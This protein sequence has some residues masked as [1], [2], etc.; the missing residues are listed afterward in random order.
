MVEARANSDISLVAE[1]SSKLAQADPSD[2]L[3]Q[4]VASNSYLALNNLELAIAFAEKACLAETDHFGHQ[5]HCGGLKNRVG[6]FSGALVIFLRLL[7]HPEVQPDAYLQAAQSV[8]NLGDF[9]LATKLINNAIQLEPTRVAS[10]MMLRA[11]A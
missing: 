6:D 7:K 1:I 8:E 11:N 3:A 2:A 9:E 5:M 10:G 4:R